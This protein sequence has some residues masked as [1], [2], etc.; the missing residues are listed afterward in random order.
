MSESSELQ[1][2]VEALTKSIGDLRNELVRKDVY[3]SD[4][5]ARDREV[6]EVMND[7]RD[8]K[9]GF[10]DEKKDHNDE[11]KERGRERR[12]DLRILYGAVAAS[13]ATLLASLYTQTQGV[14]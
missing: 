14:S 9:Q 11:R 2:A 4:Q 10:T 1:R 12:A 13:I 5:R 7:V 3:E 8:L 6:A